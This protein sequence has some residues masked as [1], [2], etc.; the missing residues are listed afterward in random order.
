MSEWVRVGQR[1][2]NLDRVSWAQYAPEDHIVA[3][4]VTLYAEGTNGEA[5]PIMEFLGE[6]AE[7]LWSWLQAN[8]RDVVDLYQQVQAME[9]RANAKDQ[10][11]RH[12]I[13]KRGG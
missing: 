4:V 13:R 12:A 9:A 5:V 6:E 8:G 7:G 10:Q 2:I 11:A 3:A 1:A